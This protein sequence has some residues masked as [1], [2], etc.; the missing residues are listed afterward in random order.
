LRVVD[1]S[2]WQAIIDQ[3]MDG[4]IIV[5]STQQIIFANPAAIEIYKQTPEE[6]IGQYCGF[7]AVNNTSVVFNP[8]PAQNLSSMVEARSTEI[9]WGERNVILATLRTIVDSQNKNEND[10]EFFCRLNPDGSII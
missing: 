6:I 10:L 5:D 7:N 9:L 8:L 3:S 2:F 4:I 1:S